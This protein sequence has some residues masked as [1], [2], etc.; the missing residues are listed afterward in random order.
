MLRRFRNTWQ[1][2]QAMR[3]SVHLHHNDAT[4]VVSLHGVIDLPMAEQIG[5]H[6]AQLTAIGN[7]VAVH[8]DLVDATFVGE[9]GPVFLPVAI[10]ARSRGIHLTAHRADAVQ[11][12]SLQGLGLERL[13]Q[14]SE[15]PAAAAA[16][17][18]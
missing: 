17:P 3:R 2:P 15:E 16:G 1:M 10:A 6:L 13:L 9:T 7:P 5:R 14:Y 8:I 12:A 4:L 18:A 11:R